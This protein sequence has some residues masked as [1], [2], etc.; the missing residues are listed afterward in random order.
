MDT[1]SYLQP[2]VAVRTA[3]TIFAGVIFG[4]DEISTRCLWPVTRTFTCV[5]PTSMTRILMRSPSLV[6]RQSAWQ[7]R[8]R[9]CL[10]HHFLAKE[11]CTIEFVTAAY[12][13]VN[14]PCQL[15]MGCGIG[16]KRHRNDGVFNWLFHIVLGDEFFPC[17]LHCP[18][19]SVASSP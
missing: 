18:T 16:V 14:L 17:F 6:V 11:R 1:A 9:H 5:P 4:P 12:L 7:D 19:S 8:L 3:E 15:V 13:F 2:T 10:V